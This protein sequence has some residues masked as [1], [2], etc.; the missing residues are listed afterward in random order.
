MNRPLSVLGSAPLTSAPL[1][2]ETEL[3]EVGIEH[4]R[5]LYHVPGQEDVCNIL[6]GVS[7]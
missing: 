3:E 6:S 1:R 5:F 2:E 7:N 4:G